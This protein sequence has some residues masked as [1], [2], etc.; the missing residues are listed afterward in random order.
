MATNQIQSCQDELLWLGGWLGG[1]SPFQVAAD[2]LK[3]AW[4]HSFV[5]I[6]LFL[7]RPSPC[8]GVLCVNMYLCVF[9]FL[10]KLTPVF[11]TSSTEERSR[12]LKKEIYIWS[13]FISHVLYTALH[14]NQL[15]FYFEFVFTINIDSQYDFTRGPPQ[16]LQMLLAMSSHAQLNHEDPSH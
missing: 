7:V 13:M 8:V 12:E 9:K 15:T 2:K 16:T 3:Y 5:C 4:H 10:T 14:E 1:F 6:T 11:S